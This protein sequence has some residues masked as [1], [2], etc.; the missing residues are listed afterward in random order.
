MQ[1]DSKTQSLKIGWAMRDISTDAPVDIPGQ[2]HI[3]VSQGVRDPV[4]TTATVI[5]NGE[6]MI[7]F[8]SVDCVSIQPRLVTAVR[9]RVA[10]ARPAIP[11]DRIVIG[12]THTHEGASHDYEAI[13]GMALPDQVP[14]DG[15][16]IA[17]PSEYGKSLTGKIAEAVCEAYDNRRPGG[18]AYGYGYATVAHSRRVVYFDDYSLRP[19]SVARPGMN[20]DGHA[21]MYGATNDDKFSHYEAGT[22]PFVNLLYTFDK[23]GRLTGAIINVPCPSQCSEHI[24]QLSADYWH[25]V[26]LAIR[27]RHGDIFILP[28]CAAGGDLAPRIM[29][30]RDAQKRRFALKYGNGEGDLDTWQRRDI[31]ERIAAAFDEVLEWARKDIHRALPIGHETACIGLSHRMITDEEA[32][33][34]RQVLADLEAT[35]FKSDGTPLERL[36]A[37]SALVARRKRCALILRRHQ[38]QQTEPTCPVELHVARLGDIAFATSPFELYMDYMHR[39]QARSPFLQ[40]FVVQLVGNP[41]GTAGYLATERGAWGQGYSASLYCNQVSP[42]GGQELVEETLARLKKL[43]GSADDASNPPKK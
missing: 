2:F 6:E 25:D 42:Q 10:A 37:D 28:Q 29:H 16:E 43:H 1:T 33:L 40:T 8:V 11:A 31:A 21:R 36:H 5:D 34:Q 26:R 19:G 4:T 38:Q 15:I 3:R 22:D 20:V 32:A 35:P 27:A 9:D 7:I 17:P 39:I 14:H 41:H 24:S 12:A 23:A 13:A 18:V 30:Y